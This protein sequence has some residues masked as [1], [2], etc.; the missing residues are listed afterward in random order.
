MLVRVKLTRA[1]K[2][3][4]VVDLAQGPRASEFSEV[5]CMLEGLT[6]AYISRSV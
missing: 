5:L 2:I 4:I 3:S 1:P 6:H